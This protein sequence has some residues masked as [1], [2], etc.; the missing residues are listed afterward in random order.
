MDLTQLEIFRA[1]A[2]EG[3]ITAA[4]QRLHRVPSNV[5][6]RLKQLE[7]ELGV[8]LFIRERLRLYL[9]PTGAVFLDYSRK[10]LDL[11]SEARGVIKGGEPHGMFTIGSLESTAAVRMP[12][13][14]ASFHQRY[15]AVQLDLTT[16]SSAEMI[17]GVTEGRLAA[18]FIDGPIGHL[19]LDGRKV[20]EEEMLVIAP[21]HH[22]PIRHPRDVAGET[23]YAFRSNCSYRRHFENWFASARVRPSRIFEMES[24]HG[25]LAC[26]SAGAG[27]AMFPR[28]MLCAMQGAEMVEA[29]PLPGSFSTVEIWLAWR[30]GL[31]HPNVSALLQE[32]NLHGELID[33]C[34]P[35]D[36]AIA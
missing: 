3:S 28:S 1:V 19:A 16:G 11:V 7:G 5:T 13:V 33:I 2:E 10:I 8:D 14:L 30:K 22:P 17:N 31:M 21:R 34:L 15:P 32:L 4:A 29:F 12:S 20:F 36:P 24:Y 35:P 9:S 26:V 23:V 6:T 18:A 27:I 25:M